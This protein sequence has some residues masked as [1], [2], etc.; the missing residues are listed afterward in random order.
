MSGRYCRQN[1]APLHPPP[2]NPDSALPPGP[3]TRCAQSSDSPAGGHERPDLMYWGSRCT[4]A[5]YLW[6]KTSSSSDHPTTVQLPQPSTL[7]IADVWH[8]MRP[9]SIMPLPPRRCEVVCKRAHTL[10][11]PRPGGG[12]GEE[13]QWPQ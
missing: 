12:G 10:A 2:P 11:F 8:Q 6:L 1:T 4:A 13:L 5:R 3:A 9:E 7:T